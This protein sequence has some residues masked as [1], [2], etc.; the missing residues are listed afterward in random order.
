MPPLPSTITFDGGTISDDLYWG[1]TTTTPG[2]VVDRA[3]AGGGTAKA[4]QYP[5]INDDE[6]TFFE[7]FVIAAPGDDTLTVRYEVSSEENYDYFRITVDGT[8][9]LEPGEP[10]VSGDGV[11]WQEFTTTLS[12]GSRTL[13]F[14][15]SKDSSADE[16]SDT[17][18]I[19]SI[20]V[21]PIAPKPSVGAST[22]EDLTS[23]GSGTTPYDPNFRL[24]R[25][26]MSEGSIITE[27]EFRETFGGAD[28]T[29]TLAG[30]AFSINEFYGPET[31]DLAFDNN[32]TVAT[33]DYTWQSVL[34]FGYVGFNFD[35]GPDDVTQVLINAPW[36]GN[37]PRNFTIERKRPEDFVW[38]IMASVEGECE[39]YSSGDNPRTYDLTG[40]DRRYETHLGRSG[41]I[42][43]ALRDF[44]DKNYVTVSLHSN[45][46][47]DM[48]ITKLVLLPYQSHPYTAYPLPPTSDL[49]KIK[50]VIYAADGV[51]GKPGTLL[52][53]TIERTRTQ[54]SANIYL[55]GDWFDLLFAAP[56]FLP[57]GSYWLGVHVGGDQ[58]MYTVQTSNFGTTYTAPATYLSGTPAS[59]PGGEATILNQPPLYAVYPVS[60]GYP[61][62]ESAVSVATGLVG[63]GDITGTASNSLALLTS[64]ASGTVSPPI[65]GLAVTLLEALTSTAQATRLRPGFRQRVSLMGTLRPTKSL[66]ATWVPK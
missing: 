34:S 41:F 61:T 7:M 12:H 57:R 51:G 23:D 28:L 21:P 36:A 47:D 63:E 62:L 50:G 31:A 22:L 45:S 6:E 18:W 9:V 64:S 20:T 29:D 10:G 17:T 65:T 55:A 54:Y 13:H 33:L 43:S 26:N 27:I 15:Y 38:E 24:W 30:T 66:N 39:W 1:G 19:S 2:S 48:S 60:R 14:S 16:G 42:F 35:H 58:R 32:T 5:D 53:T 49:F 46:V 59:W 3:D 40:P 52:A 56:V 4:L 44:C 8:D 11:G 25:V 37:A